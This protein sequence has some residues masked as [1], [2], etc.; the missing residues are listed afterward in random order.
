MTVRLKQVRITIDVKYKRLIVRYV[1][2]KFT[3]SLTHF[4]S[5][6]IPPLYARAAFYDN[7]EGIVP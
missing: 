3:N 7:L 2:L 1:I 4:P 6:E 5:I